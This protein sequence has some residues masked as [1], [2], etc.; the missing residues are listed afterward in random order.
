MDQPESSIWFSCFSSL[1]ASYSFCSSDI[2]SRGF[3]VF[4]GRMQ[5]VTGFT[6]KRISIVWEM[7]RICK[8]GQILLYVACYCLLPFWI[9]N[10]GTYLS[11][12]AAYSSVS[13]SSLSA[14]LFGIFTCPRR[15]ALAKRPAEWPNPVYFIIRA[16]E[17][18]PISSKIFQKSP[19]LLQ[20]TNI[21]SL[22]TVPAFPTVFIIRMSLFRRE[23]PSSGCRFTSTS[24]KGGRIWNVWLICSGGNLQ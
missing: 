20:R 9:W 23:S 3:T 2:P 4:C 11:S 22:A 19:D 17:I 16:T 13:E 12:T 24:F 5:P 14:L 8:P 6:L 21:S 15:P 10:N 1:S 18:L 7:V